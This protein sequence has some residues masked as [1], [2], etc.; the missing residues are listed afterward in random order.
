MNATNQPEP[1]RR[2]CHSR[3]WSLMLFVSGMCLLLGCANWY[4]RPVLAF[5]NAAYQL[6]EIAAPAPRGN[7]WLGPFMTTEVDYSETVTR[8]P[9]D[10]LAHVAGSLAEVSRHLESLPNLRVLNLKRLPIDDDDLQYLQAL[11]DL[12]ELDLRGTQVT[13]ECVKRLQRALPNCKIEH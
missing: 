9:E 7:P 6:R 1:K 3:L 11:T 10:M 4:L 13:E 2:W 12:E 8:L 5:K